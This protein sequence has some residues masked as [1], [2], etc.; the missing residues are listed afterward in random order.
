MTCEAANLDCVKVLLQ[1]HANVNARTDTGGCAL[2][3]ACL[4]DNY[5]L[6]DYLVANGTD[7]DDSLIFDCYQTLVYVNVR[8]S[9]KLEIA[10]TLLSYVKN[11]N[12]T[13]TNVSLL[14]LAST[15]GHVELVNVL[16]IMG[17]DR[18]AVNRMGYD[19]PYFASWH[20]YL[21][22]VKLLLEGNTV[23]STASVDA[24]LRAMFVF[25]MF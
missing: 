23:F 10:K 2:I 12:F 24:A 8:F 6:F 7:L 4:S 3:S 14:H 19:A 20:G 16:L 18:T 25:P 11:I 9:D 1:N 13:K 21:D 17:A 22:I 15:A 5:E